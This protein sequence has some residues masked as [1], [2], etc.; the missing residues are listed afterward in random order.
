MFFDGF[1]MRPNGVQLVIQGNNKPS[2]EVI[3]EVDWS[4]T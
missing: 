2:G 1:K 4:R 3:F